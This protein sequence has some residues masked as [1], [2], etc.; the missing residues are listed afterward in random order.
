MMFVRSSIGSP[1]IASIWQTLFSFVASCQTHGRFGSRGNDFSCRCC[2]MFAD[3][4]Y[5]VTVEG[6]GLLP[7]DRV[8][9]LGQHDELGAGDMSEL[10]AH[11]PGRRLQVLIAGHQQ[12]RHPN[13]LELL[14]CDRSSLRL[15]WRALLLRVMMNLQPALQTLRVG[16]HISDA[17]FPKFWRPVP[18][19]RKRSPLAKL[20]QV[21]IYDGA[22]A[23]SDDQAAKSLRMP[24]NVVIRRES[25]AGHADEMK[26]VE[27]QV[28]HQSMQIIRDGARLSTG[29]RIRPAAAPSPAIEGDNSISR[30]DKARNVVLPAV[31]VA[32]VC[33][34]QYDRYTVTAAVCVPEAHAGEV[35]VSCESWAKSL[36]GGCHEQEQRSRVCV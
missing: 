16:R 26:S 14:E 23:G 35:C 30:L 18:K 36:G 27:P 8:R 11:D 33:V 1:F 5:D 21:F 19:P 10:P 17:H 13:R 7:V 31:G 29:V 20:A 32:C 9:S 15:C 34:E 6:F 4:F 24:E 12:G 28:L 22:A 25:A 2:L 3:E